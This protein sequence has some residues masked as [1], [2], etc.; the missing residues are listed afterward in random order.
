MTPAL[1]MMTSNGSHA[2]E[3]GQIQFN[4]LQTAAIR[5]SI[6][7]Y[8]DR[9]GFGFGQI[10]RGANNMRTVS[11]KR[12]RGFDTKSCRNARDENALSSEIYPG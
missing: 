7:S 10:A 9:G 5:R 3:A 4:Q 1:A 11:R 8:L 6:L 12:T 2:L